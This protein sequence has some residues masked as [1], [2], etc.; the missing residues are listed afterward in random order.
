MTCLQ[1]QTTLQSKLLMEIQ[2]C[3]KLSWLS[4]WKTPSWASWAESIRKYVR[5]ACCADQISDR[6]WHL[7][8]SENSLFSINPGSPVPDGW[9]CDIIPPTQGSSLRWPV[10]EFC[11][12]LDLLHCEHKRE[13][14]YIIE[15][16][17][18]KSFA[19]SFDV[20]ISRVACMSAQMQDIFILPALF[21]LFV[22]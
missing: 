11:I 14:G 16:M 21:F 9:F 17:V 6:S 15:E 1:Q 19:I 7:E 22:R 8:W 10:K 18:M 4:M 12:I 13:S 20:E 5:A 2:T 3:R